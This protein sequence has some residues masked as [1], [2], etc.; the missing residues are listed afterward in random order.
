MPD[1]KEFTEFLS[2][3]RDEFFSPPCQEITLAN[4]PLSR[5]DFVALLEKLRNDTIR[6]CNSHNLEVLQAYHYWLRKQI[7]DL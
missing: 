2:E 6:A 7:G 3:H 1:F 5:E 4:G